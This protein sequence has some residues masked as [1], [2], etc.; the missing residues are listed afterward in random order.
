MVLSEVDGN[1][2]TGICFV[3]YENRA[4]RSGLFLVPVAILTFGFSVFFSFKGVFNLNR[5]KRSTTSAKEMKTLSSH[6][7]GMGIRTMLIVFFIFA[8]FI[9]ENYEARNSKIW[10]KSLDDFIVYVNVILEII[11][12]F[13]IHFLHSLISSHSF[14]FRCKIKES[15]IGDMSICKMHSRPSVAVLQ[16]RLICLFCVNLVVSSWCWTWPT[17][18]TWNRFIKKYVETQP[19]LLLLHLKYVEPSQSILEKF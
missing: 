12:T 5:I 15:Y 2:I 9:F 18:K 10:A 13:F 4:I 17:L 11:F 19:F 1:S 16:L 7:L 8:F 3:G 6:I 14:T